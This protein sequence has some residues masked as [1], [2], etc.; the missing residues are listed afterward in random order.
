MILQVPRRARPALW[1]A[2]VA[3][4]LLAACASGSLA[5]V[6]NPGFDTPEPTLLGAG[7]P[8]TATLGPT[9]PITGVSS[10]ANWLLLNSGAGTITSTL[11]ASTD[12]LFASPGNMINIRASNAFAGVTQHI[13]M[14]NVT[15]ASVDLLVPTGQQA[16]LALLFNGTFL[17]YVVANGT[18]QWQTISMTGNWAM[19]NEVQVR[20]STAAS[21]FSADRVVVNN[22]VPE[23]GVLAL[24]GS[25]LLGAAGAFLRR[26]RA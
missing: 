20:T 26:R 7:P 23:P 10:A 2:V 13:S 11:T 5:Q 24:F 17:N 12:P 15:S 22:T 9:D 6:L 1:S 3:A 19:V 21:G 4:V 8:Y 14:P 16:F 18:G 25:G